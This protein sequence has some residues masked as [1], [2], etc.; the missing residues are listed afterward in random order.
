MLPEIASLNERFSQRLDL[1]E[2]GKD[3]GLPKL[4]EAT[5]CSRILK[6]LVEFSMVLVAKKKVSLQDLERIVAAWANL[7]SKSFKET[8]DWEIEVEKY[9][10]FAVR[11]EQLYEIGF[12]IFQKVSIYLS[13]G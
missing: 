2:S 7:C 10:D 6:S 13:F 4:W 9:S 12:Q 1:V 8:S 5:L 3:D 11:S